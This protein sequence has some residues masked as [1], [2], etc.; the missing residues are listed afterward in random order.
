[1]SSS[2][3]RALDIDINGNQGSKGQK[4]YEQSQVVDNL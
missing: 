1:M 3:L 4:A 2:V